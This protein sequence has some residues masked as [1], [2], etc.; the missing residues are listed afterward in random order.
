[1]KAGECC[2]A[3]DEGA[4]LEDL[5][6]WL[7]EKWRVDPEEAR[8]A[9]DEWKAKLRPTSSVRRRA[10]DGQGRLGSVYD[11]ELLKADSSSSSSDSSSSSKVSGH[12]KK[13]RVEKLL[14][15]IGR[16]VSWWSSTA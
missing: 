5:K 13:Q 8:T 16:T 11:A 2:L 10:P 15:R 9:V 4:V 12:P 6:V 3:F 7:C 1:M 14:R